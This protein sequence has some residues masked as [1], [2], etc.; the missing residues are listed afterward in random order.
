MNGF[1]ARGRFLSVAGRMGGLIG[2]GLILSVSAVFL[3][4]C[5][6]SEG[7]SL[8]SMN[9]FQRDQAAATRDGRPGSRG[10]DSASEAEFSRLLSRGR[11]A[12]E[13]GDYDEARQAYQEMIV[14]FPD[15]HEG[16]YY[17][18]VVADHE[19]RFREAESLFSQAILR[20]PLEAKYHNSL[21]YCFLL[22]RK[23]DDAEAALRKAV[24]LQPSNE[25]FR[26]NLGMVYGHQERYADAIEQ[27]RRAGSVADAYCNLAFVL[28]SQ[29]KIAEA[30]NAYYLA[31]RADPT[32][33]RAERLLTELESYQRDPRAYAAEAPEI[34]ADGMRWV[35][36]VEQDQSEPSDLAALETAELQGFTPVRRRGTSLQRIGDAS[37]ESSLE[38]LRPRV[39][40]WG[41]T[42]PL[43]E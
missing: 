1:S 16:Y 34:D 5:Q 41:D 14:A 39:A 3:A 22:Q 10:K 19:K 18:G 9:P 11:K 42:R 6:P 13:T 32:S 36:Y 2:G 30:K 37:R 27:F 25:R 33:D 26:T 23:L 35:R 8:A 38:S 17:L 21:G 28:E 24:A 40:E 31:M 43:Y 4:G 12:K 15:R 20:R 29:G 7:F